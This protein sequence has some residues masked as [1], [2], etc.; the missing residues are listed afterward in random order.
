MMFYKRGLLHLIRNKRKS[1]VLLVVIFIVGVLLFGAVSMRSAL[2]AST[3]SIINRIPS[4]SE[5][6]FNY[7]EAMGEVGGGFNV[8]M[9]ERVPIPTVTDL[10]DVGNLPYVR[11][12]DIT[13]ETRLFGRD[14]EWVSSYIDGA[15]LPARLRGSNGFSE[16][17]HRIDGIERR[18]TG[19]IPV[20]GVTNPSLLEIEA[21]VSTL[22]EGR[23]FTSSEIETGAR[24]A[25]ISE[26]FS[27][28][29]EISIG[30]FLPL[31]SIVQDT[32]QMY[33][34][35][36]GIDGQELY[37]FISELADERFYAFREIL[38]FEVVGIF[39]LLKGFDYDLIQEANNLEFGRQ[40]NLWADMKNM[41]YI[42]FT[43]IPPIIEA[44]FEALLML[45]T[46]NQNENRRLDRAIHR[47]V[48]VRSL[49]LELTPGAT[50]ILNSPQYLDSFSK[51]ASEILPDF[52][53]VE[54]FAKNFAPILITIEPLG[55]IADL[56]LWIAIGGGGT[57][58]SLLMLLS[59]QTRTHEM[60]LYLAL[61][62]QKGKIVLQFLMEVLFLGVIGVGLSTLV[63][64]ILSNALS[65]E[66]FQR[67]IVQRESRNLMQATSADTV[68]G[69]TISLFFP[70]EI[71]NEELF[72]M[73]DTSLSSSS[74]TFIVAIAFAIILTSTLIPVLRIV[75]IKPKKILM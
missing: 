18:L 69:R 46:E 34:E 7:R 67:A 59:L 21:G 64:N 70:G 3:E 74:I 60:G 40:L 39:S 49:E 10:E 57:A 61:G 30:D 45:S 56:I 41:I 15:K 16:E 36:V 22:A 24:V 66:L 44:E 32:V 62:S 75:F 11:N 47:T 43:V 48:D 58:L 2:I 5:L 13:L 14:L 55:E 71:T 23:T 37:P 63:G 50:F 26:E 31:E 9:D 42:P 27:R 53:E 54:D 35:G 6:T 8:I 29:N 51:A 65:R 52:W 68:V 73:Y 17:I 38:K 20:R 72:S 1:G 25:I 12:F 19:R 4:V 28:L 33:R